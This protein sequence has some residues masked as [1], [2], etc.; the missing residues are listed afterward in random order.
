M[1]TGKVKIGVVCRCRG[2]GDLLYQITEIDKEKTGV[3][4][5]TLDGYA[6]GWKSIKQLTCVPESELRAKLTRM[7]KQMKVLTKVLKQ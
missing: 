4:L 2:D 6:G 5:E 7:Q 3:F 1:R